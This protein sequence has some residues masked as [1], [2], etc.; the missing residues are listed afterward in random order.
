MPPLDPG[1]AIQLGATAL[2]AIKG[3]GSLFGGEIG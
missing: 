2:N 3:I 1:T